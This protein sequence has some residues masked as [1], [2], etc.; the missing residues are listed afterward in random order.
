VLS[1]LALYML[2]FYEVPN[3]ILKKLDTF[4]GPDSSGKEIIIK[5]STGYQS[6]ILSTEQRRRRARNSRPESSKQ[7]YPYQMDFQLNQ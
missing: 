4:I 2:S 7:M 6:G 3:E 1:S 5:R